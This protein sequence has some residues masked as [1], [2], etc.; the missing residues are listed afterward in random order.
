MKIVQELSR[1]GLVRDLDI[2]CDSYSVSKS[3]KAPC[4]KL[5]D[6]QTKNVLEL[7]HSDL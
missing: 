4:K 3:T 2:H 5:G 1:N 6:R 7:I